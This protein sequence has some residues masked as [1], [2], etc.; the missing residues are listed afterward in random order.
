MFIF[1]PK[2]ISTVQIHKR[3]QSSLIKNVDILNNLFLIIV[4]YA[5][6][7][8]GPFGGVRVLGVTKKVIRMMPQVV[9]YPEPGEGDRDGGDGSRLGTLQIADLSVQVALVITRMLGENKEGFRF[10]DQIVAL[11]MFHFGVAMS[12]VVTVA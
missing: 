10:R 3:F 11:C 5:K 8:V 9:E 12:M 6:L 2:F 1:I 4:R 7:F